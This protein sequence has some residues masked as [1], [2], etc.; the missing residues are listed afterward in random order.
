MLEAA[1]EIWRAAGILT[2]RQEAMLD[3]VM[4]TVADLDGLTLARVE[5]MG[6]TLDL[7]AAGHGW[8]VDPTPETAEE[9]ERTADG[10]LVATSEAS[11]GRMDLLSV[12]LHEIGHIVG[13]D[14][15]DALAVMAPSLAVGTRVVETE[16]VFDG[17]S[18]T[19]T[20]TEEPSLDYIVLTDEDDGAPAGALIDWGNTQKR[21][22]RGSVTR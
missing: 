12:L 15:D 6:I 14:H 4:L 10:T 8:F 7:D 20:S 2:T 1:I 9:F 18:G 17:D 11:T 22:G 3:E 21:K 16:L 5:G 13:F 19:L